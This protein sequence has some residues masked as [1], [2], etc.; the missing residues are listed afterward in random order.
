MPEAQVRAMEAETLGAAH[1]REHATGRAL[2]HREARTMRT[3][4]P[5]ERRVR[6]ERAVHARA[7]AA[8]A[9]RP[10]SEVGEWSERYGLPDYVM[11]AALLHTG[12]VAMWGWA[13][14]DVEGQ[15]PLDGETY[16]WDSARELPALSAAT[17]S[18]GA[19]RR[20][21]PPPI[22]IGG[23]TLP[24]PLYCSGISF[25]PDGRLLIAGGNRAFPDPNLGTGWTG[26]DTIF[27]Y[28][29]KTRGWT[30]GPTMHA[31]R[32]YPTQLML[33]DGRTWIG[34]GLDETGR[35]TLPVDAEVLDAGARM[36]TRVAPPAPQGPETADAPAS[37]WG[38]PGWPGMYPHA[39]V[40]P[41]G[42]ALVLPD[43]YSRAAGL[44]TIP[45]A[46]PATYVHDGAR[47]FVGGRHDREG[48]TAVLDPSPTTAP[49]ERVVQ[50]GGLS[51]TVA[52]TGAVDGRAKRDVRSITPGSLPTPLPFTAGEPLST[53]RSYHNTV[54]LPGGDLVTVGGGAGNDP[55]TDPATSE[56]IYWDN[57]R[58]PALLNAELR[59]AATGRWTVAAPQQSFRS[60]HSVA[61]LLPDG[62]VWSAGD[63]Y[64]SDRVRRETGTPWRGNAEIFSPPYL[65]G[66]AD[67]VTGTWD[68]DRPAQRPQVT[69]APA[70]L[71]WGLELE[72]ETAGPEVRDV[73]L[74]APGA[75]TH[76]IDTNQRHVRLAVT[77]R[78]AGRL[79]AR[80]DA[81]ATTAPPGRYML[82]ALTDRGTPSH[83]RWVHVGEAPPGSGSGSGSDP[84]GPPML[85]PPGP[86]P[87]PAIPPAT[88]PGAP[89]AP[90]PAARPIRVTLA[91]PAG[92]RTALRR[93]GRLRVSVT[94]SA[95]RR[96]QLTV[97]L[98][99]GRASV[100]LRRTVTHPG[101]RPTSV[102][103]PLSR[104]AQALLRRRGPI[105]LTVTAH[106]A[107]AVRARALATL[108]RSL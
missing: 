104:A 72:L 59:D 29:P 103:M 10:R 65:F 36:L 102:S 46:G 52:G 37:H 24:A 64:H 18:R 3:A 68:P 90:A 73:V 1:A 31:G 50:I 83:A 54:I 15:R 19:V 58:D 9:G 48:S 99:S 28:D 63:D 69:R 4:N 45:T 14:R 11:H 94:A 38:L 81:D 30:Q 25:L 20:Q 66:A 79:T 32:W 13:P 70:Q 80:L 42:Q 67:P 51:Y 12:E 40:M 86:A 105:A 61:L 26:L 82:F 49:S 74:V 2:A 8:V 16:F 77:G 39:F 106:T 93:S 97:R 5:A 41:G 100:V 107:G 47:P 76:A 33:A 53:G 60:Y 23:R 91:V 7:R 43:E 89:P 101:G 71:S 62:R 88:G 17:D 44:M 84:D 57:G 96:L 95:K 22:A 56:G 6:S 87:A 92:S 98:R 55:D 75:P 108:R 35:E 21:D 27:I 85:A 78:S 34:G